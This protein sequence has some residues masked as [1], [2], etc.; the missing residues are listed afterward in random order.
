MSNLLR[1]CCALL[2]ALASP[3]VSLRAQTVANLGFEERSLLDPTRPATWSVGA[4]AGYAAELDSV[5]A[6]GGRLSLRIRQTSAAT[7]FAV[8]NQ[9]IPVSAARGKRVRLRGWIRTEGVTRGQAA[10]W[11]RV[12]GPGNRSLAFDNMAGRGASGTSPWTR[13]EIELPVDSAATG[14]IFGA[15]DNGD[16]TAWFDDVEIA[17]DGVPYDPATARAWEATPAQAAWVRRHAIPLRTDAPGGDDA[18]LR[19]L[20]PLVAG[21]RIVALGEGTHGTR[22]FFRAKHRLVQ[23]MVEREGVTVFTIEANMPEARRV[24]EYVLTGRGDPRAAL[25][26]L[27]FWTW[28]TEE[29]LALMEWMRAYNASGRGR[30]EFWGFDMQFP[31]VAADSVRAFVARADPA[32]LPQAD[33]ASA[34]A[35]SAFEAVRRGGRADSVQARV[36]RDAAARVLAHLAANRTTYLARFDT[37]QVDWAEQNARIVE[38]AARTMLAG[39]ASRDSSMAENV[40]WIAA[41]HP[42]GTRMV[43]WAHNG[44]VSRAPGA[45]GAHLDHRF[46]SAYRV[47][48]FAFGEGE[49]TAIGPRGLASYPAAAPEAGS[50]ESVL[51]S[52]G[53]P[54]FVLDLRGAAEEENGAWLAAPHAFRSIGAGAMEH[55]FRDTP[56]ARYFDALVYFDQTTPSRPL[57]RGPMR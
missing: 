4:P 47:F 31:G 52:T 26:G 27:Y 13:Y 12:D 18:D 8:A 15:L 38:Q 21:A 17:L 42:T 32:F 51:R 1:T 43:L 57:P 24:N 14:V 50:V 9:V 49:Y 44:H 2:I 7:R 33:S 40:A 5:A 16:G 11:M 35:T 10:F 37:M 28:N 36:W 20:R 19:A 22:E 55:P 3:A 39:P 45:M 29:V 48:G 56:V 53:M 6:H 54:R 25:A 30:V 34:I 46:G 23:W 41:H